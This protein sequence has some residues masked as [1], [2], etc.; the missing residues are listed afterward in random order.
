VGEDGK[1]SN[2]YWKYTIGTSYCSYEH[3]EALAITNNAFSISPDGQTI[4]GKFRSA[5]SFFGTSPSS[6][7]C[8]GRV[9][10]STGGPLKWWVRLSA[11]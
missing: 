7:R 6:M 10:V 5:T 11:K 8:G 9:F 4:G 3:K 2:F 1:I